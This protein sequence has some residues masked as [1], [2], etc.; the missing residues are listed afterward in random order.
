[1]RLSRTKANW[2]T[3]GSWLENEMGCVLVHLQARVMMRCD[4]T[5]TMVD[6]GFQAT[7]DSA[8]GEVLLNTS[9]EQPR[10]DA[11]KTW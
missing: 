10:K 6:K 2:I 4:V 5:M 3:A 11:Y 9:S 1:M 7:R 8:M